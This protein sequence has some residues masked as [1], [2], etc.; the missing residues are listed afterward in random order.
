M[1]RFSARAEEIHGRLEDFQNWEFE[2]FQKYFEVITKLNACTRGWLH[3]VVSLHYRQHTETVHKWIHFLPR[4][5]NFSSFLFHSPPKLLQSVHD[6]ISGEVGH[7]ATHLQL[8]AVCKWEFPFDQKINFLKLLSII[9]PTY[10]NRPPIHDS[11]YQ[12]SSKKREV[13]NHSYKLSL[14]I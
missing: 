1:L 7:C 5:E 12:N 3:Q 11:C 8:K 2:Q 10:H 4:P 14:Q 6:K 9:Q 13:K